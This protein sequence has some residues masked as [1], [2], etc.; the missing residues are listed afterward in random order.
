MRHIILHLHKNIFAHIQILNVIPRYVQKSI[1]ELEFTTDFHFL[2]S[3]SVSTT[4]LAISM[5]QLA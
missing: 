5:V 3:V 2:P 1:C 4:S